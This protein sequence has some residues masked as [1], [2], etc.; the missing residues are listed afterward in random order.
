MNMPVLEV[1][2]QRVDTES[3]DILEEEGIII[4]MDA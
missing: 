3:N 4:W 1:M 2:V